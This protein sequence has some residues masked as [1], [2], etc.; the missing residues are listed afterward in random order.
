MAVDVGVELLRALPDL[1]VEF[2]DDRDAVGAEHPERSRSA[3]QAISK[4]F[5]LG[6]HFPRP[7]CIELKICS[8]PLVIG[9]QQVEAA[10]ER[11]K[12]T[13]ARMVIPAPILEGTL[14]G[15]R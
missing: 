13:C 9:P 11:M 12:A 6:P 4:A 1:P 5:A 7:D 10:V 3:V 15:G 14:N 8:P 2:P